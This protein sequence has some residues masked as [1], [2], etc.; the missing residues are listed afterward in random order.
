MA[1][2]MIHHSDGENCGPQ[3]GRKKESHI[4]NLFDTPITINLK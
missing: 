2:C 3:Q 1:E 4:E